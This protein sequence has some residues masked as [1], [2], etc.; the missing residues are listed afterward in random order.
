MTVPMSESGGGVDGRTL[1]VGPG[2]AARAAPPPV[3]RPPVP[4]APAFDD[5]LLSVAAAFL[6]ERRMIV[7]R[8]PSARALRQF[9]VDHPIVSQQIRDVPSAFNPVKEILIGQGYQY[10]LN[11]R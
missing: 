3:A 8:G 9:C 4:A 10:I 2:T 6:N 5:A 1:A 7:L 11:A